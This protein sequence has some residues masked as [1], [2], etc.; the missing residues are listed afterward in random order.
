MRHWF[1]TLTSKKNNLQN[2]IWN[3]VRNKNQSLCIEQKF[4][5]TVGAV[6][7]DLNKKPKW[8]I[9]GVHGNYNY[10]DLV[11]NDKSLIE[12]EIH[13]QWKRFWVELGSES[14]I[15]LQF[16]PASENLIFRHNM[17]IIVM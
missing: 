10:S 15:A 17:K 12:A 14:T 5:S 8:F 16:P 3:K 11:A 6:C 13:F 2:S 9:L 7:G 4:A 1:E